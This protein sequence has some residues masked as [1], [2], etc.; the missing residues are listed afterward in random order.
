MRRIRGNGRMATA[1]GGT[2]DSVAKAM[3]GGTEVTVA[4][5]APIAVHLVYRTAWLEPDGMVAFRSDFYRRDRP[6]PN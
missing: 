1:A 4:L 3:T 6:N 5:P 2:S